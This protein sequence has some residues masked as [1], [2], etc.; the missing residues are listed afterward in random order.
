M[1]SSRRRMLLLFTSSALAFALLSAGAVAVTPDASAQSARDQ[2]REAYARGKQLFDGGKFQAAIGE[3]EKARSLAPSP[4]LDFNIGLCHDRLG[5]AGAALVSYRAY[6]D[7]VPN[8]GNRAAVESRIK[9]LEPKAAA[10]MQPLAPPDD[11]APAPAPPTP[12]PEADVPAPPPGTA[13]PVAPPA[14]A[15]T[16]ETAPA[17]PALGPGLPQRT[18]DPELDRV[19]RI[20]LAAVRARF[21]GAPPPR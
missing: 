13:P 10:E 21:R 3:F 5:N 16:P 19:L 8:A 1:T 6:L 18:G 11:P 4:V 7:A 12:S 15:I 9:I 20:D 2:A 17:P 14:S